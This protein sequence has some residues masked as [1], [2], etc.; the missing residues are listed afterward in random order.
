MKSM[1]EELAFHPSAQN[2]SP[3]L[4]ERRILI[5]VNYNPSSNIT[6]TTYEV[7]CSHLYLAVDYWKTSSRYENIEWAVPWSFEESTTPTPQG[8]LV[9][10]RISI[11]YESHKQFPEV[12]T[13]NT[14]VR[15]PVTLKK[16]SFHWDSLKKFDIY[17]QLIQRAKLCNIILLKTLY[18]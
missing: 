1:V 7:L 16:A 3:G 15:K 12:I 17:L 14:Q 8:H 18:S 5:F 6:E 9:W 10:G 2:F 13:G 11:N 4:K